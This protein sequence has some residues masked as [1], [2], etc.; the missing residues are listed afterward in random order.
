[1][2]S[3]S[4]LTRVVDPYG[5]NYLDS[6]AA[7]R[8]LSWSWD[9][10][11]GP[12]DASLSLDAAAD[13]QVRNLSQGATLTTH[14]GGITWKG[15]VAS[16]DRDGW[17]V[18][19][20]GLGGL[21]A[22]E[23]VRITGTLD[24]IVDDC[25]ANGLP[26]TRP[27]SLSTQQWGQAS[28]TDGPTDLSSVTLDQVLTEVLNAAGKFW[29][30]TLAGQILAEAAPTA[31][32]LMVQVST[33]PP[34]TLNT[35]ATRITALYGTFDSGGGTTAQ[36]TVV[37]TAA[38]A[39]FGRVPRT[40]DIT[41]LGGIAATAATASAQAYLDRLSPR[42]IVSGDV[43]LQP[44]QVL[45]G[46]GAPVDLALLRPGVVARIHLLTIQRDALVVPTS[47]VDMLIGRVSYD[48]DSG[49]ATIAPVG[50]APDPVTTM[51]GGRGVLVNAAAA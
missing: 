32:T 28:G 49:V 37:N 27:V 15:R 47:A 10:P 35:Y 34:M 14:R 11:G 33:D 6:V 29:R 18:S 1:M 21:V 7:V 50:A 3:E 31:P 30:V 4:V 22:L 38:E 36:V 39:R 20:H 19:G 23:P 40:I 13:A 8:S 9:Y 45:T 12:T 25:I 42:M 48:A 51:F 5:W 41:H 17:Q 44:G 43:P 26:L 16:I 24:A 46:T 2:V